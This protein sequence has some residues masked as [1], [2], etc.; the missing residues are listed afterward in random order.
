M[1]VSVDVLK[2]IAQ[3]LHI[4]REGPTEV[5]P[6]GRVKVT[7]EPA[8]SG[9]QATDVVSGAVDAAFITKDIRFNNRFLEPSLA[10]GALDPRILNG[11][12]IVGIPGTG[13]LT[14]V[15][16]LLGQLSGNLPIPVEVP[17]SVRVRWTV[18]DAAGNELAE[19]VD[20]TA[21]DGRDA[22]TATF[23]FALQIVELASLTDPP[24]P[25]TR[26]IRARVVVSAGG[27]TIAVNDPAHPNNVTDVTIP[28]VPVLIA[29]LPIPTILALFL[30]SDFAPRDGD[31]DGA[32]LIVVPA[33]SPLRS[34]EQVQPLL[35]T[36]E[37]TVSSLTSIARFA[38][39]LL[40]LQTLKQALAAQPHV[41]FRATNRIGDLNDITLIQ[42][43]LISNDTEAEDELSS[44]IFIGPPG[45]TVQCFNEDSTDSGEGQFDLTIARR[46]VEG[47]V[48]IGEELF[49][50]VRTLHARVPASEPTGQEL[51]VVVP[52]TESNRFGDELSSLQF[53]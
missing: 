7:L 27:T 47:E 33:N 34:F 46:E 4:V 3:S 19:G 41:Q 6:G 53:V 26:F 37:S 43:G 5:P 42:R 31:D 51:V 40:G 20:Y 18:L 44:I 2:G 48:R 21:P 25:V 50:F 36:L 49:T 23:A 9:L 30:H 32:V 38:S 12:P 15:P 16:G 35:D 39:F 10:A 28:D 17:V 52:S 13:S 22:V 14:D 29:A 8:A 11:Q 45:K 24:L 1:P